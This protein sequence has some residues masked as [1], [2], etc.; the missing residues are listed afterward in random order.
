MRL[1]LIA[2]N[3]VGRQEFLEK[4]GRPVWRRHNG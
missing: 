2:K 4:P 1:K 3:T